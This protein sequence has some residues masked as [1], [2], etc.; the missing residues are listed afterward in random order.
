MRA[1][2]LFAA[3]LLFSGCSMLYSF[4]S[5]E[6]KFEAAG[7]GKDGVYR[8]KFNENEDILIKM[9]SA[10]TKEGEKYRII[11]TLRIP[12]DSAQ[13]DFDVGNKWVSKYDCS[14]MYCEPN[15]DREEVVLEWYKPGRGLFLG[16]I[17]LKNLRLVKAY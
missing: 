5:K 12:S 17:S 4:Y 8:S 2:A 15:I 11:Y 10:K 9:T 1:F 3:A 14:Q 16:G 13:T 6:M 7:F